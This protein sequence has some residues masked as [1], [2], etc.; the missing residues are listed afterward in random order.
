MGFL[1]AFKRS[2][3]GVTGNLGWSPF[4]AHSISGVDINQLTALTATTVLAAVTMLCEDF[5][6]LTPTI[7]RQN[8]DK[9]RSPATDHELYPLLYRP[10][11]YQDYFQFAEMMQFSLVLR[12]DRKSV[13]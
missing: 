8:A 4:T 9:S 13:V 11:D 2:E 7:Y 1:T 12:G 3:D 10:N 6:K 5:A